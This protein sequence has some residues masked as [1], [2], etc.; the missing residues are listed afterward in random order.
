MSDRKQGILVI[1]NIVSVDRV[2][3]APD[4]TGGNL[5][6][7]ALRFSLSEVID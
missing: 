4:W 7:I 2:L 1:G 5:H 6:T 3:C